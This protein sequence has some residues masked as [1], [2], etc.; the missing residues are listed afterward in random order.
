MTW[1]TQPRSNFGQLAAITCGHGPSVVL[2]HG[3]GLRAEAW[4]AQTDALSE[5]RRISAVDMPGHSESQ[6]LAQDPTLA[7]FT[8]AI[9]AGFDEPSVVIGHSFG[10]MI[11]LN[12]AARHPRLVKGVAA[13]NAIYRRTA[14]SQSAVMA[15]ANSL[16][17]ET[18]ADP[19]PTLNRWFG[20]DQSP[21]RAACDTWLRTVDPIGYRDAYR[22]FAKEDGPADAD[23]AALDCP[24]LF[25]TG[26]R[27][28]NS[29]PEMSQ[30]M[31]ALVPNG[32]AKIVADAAHMLPM[33]HAVEVNAALTKFVSE[34]Q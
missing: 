23:L 19:T 5:A 14:A 20:S 10:A 22:V 28:P 1:K 6:P 18:V 15:R 32:S 21:E 4:G 2:I 7:A 11:A 24:A 8:D 16:D 30:Q 25:L 9:V 29:T 31:A 26:S 13:L 3:V 34:C 12:L 27:E 33:T 17:G